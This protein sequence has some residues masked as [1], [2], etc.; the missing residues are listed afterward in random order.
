MQVTGKHNGW[1][2]HWQADAHK[3]AVSFSCSFGATLCDQMQAVKHA[4]GILHQICQ[5]VFT[6]FLSL[7]KAA[8]PI[9]NLVKGPSFPVHDY[10]NRS[11]CWI[12]QLC[13]PWILPMAASPS[14]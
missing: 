7:P 5:H 11:H 4:S 12:M 3:R 8:L 2:L 6:A 14:P 9:P 1:Q 10:I 13:M